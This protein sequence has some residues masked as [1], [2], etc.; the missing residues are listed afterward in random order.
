ML[1]RVSVRSVHLIRAIVARSDPCNSF[2][3]ENGLNNKLILRS[4]Y[5]LRTS[6]ACDLKDRQFLQEES[7]HINLPQN[8]PKI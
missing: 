5:V 8:L 3:V 1:V 2:K 7:I 4:T 6:I